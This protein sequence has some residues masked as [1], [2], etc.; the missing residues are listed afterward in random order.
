MKQCLKSASACGKGGEIR[1]RSRGYLPHWEREGGVYFI[2]FRLGDSLPQHVLEQIREHRRMLEEAKKCGR[3]LL[4]VESVLQQKLSQ[5]KIEE[6][7]DAGSGECLFKRPELA[8]IV[9]DALRFWDGERCRMS[10]WCVMPNHVHVLTELIADTQLG[11]LISGWKSCT[12]REVNRLLNRKGNMWQ[13][14]Y[15]DHLIRDEDEL[16]R[17]VD[18]IRNNPIRAGLKNWPWVYVRERGKKK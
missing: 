17:A 16:A 14:E 18:Y 13:R 12:T 5:R 1:I 11:E 3:D 7:L 4:A 2:T 10:A 15:Y 6:Y 9:A 8:K